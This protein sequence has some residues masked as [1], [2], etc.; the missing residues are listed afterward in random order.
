MQPLY[1]VAAHLVLLCSL[2]QPH[3]SQEEEMQRSRETQ[4][5]DCPPLL[6]ANPTPHDPNTSCQSCNESRCK[7]RGCVSLGA[8]GPTWMPDNCT[9]C[10]C[11]VAA[12]E[13]VCVSID[14]PPTRSAMATLWYTRQVSAAPSVTSTSVPTS[15]G[16]FPCVLS[17]Y[18]WHWVM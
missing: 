10:S 14:C 11:D 6:C 9:V 1:I 18:T 8:F 5:P 2:V 13:E 12:N 7:F 16:R 4:R 3:T 17:H 15:V